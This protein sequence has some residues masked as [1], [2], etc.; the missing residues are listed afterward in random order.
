[1]NPVIN[2]EEFQN[3]DIDEQMARIMGFSNFDS[4]K[5]TNFLFNCI[6][7]INNKI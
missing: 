4:S 1:M 3:M 2:E 5:V 6:K 7:E